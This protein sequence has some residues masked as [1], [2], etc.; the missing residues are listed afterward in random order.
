MSTLDLDHAIHLSDLKLPVGVTIPLL[1]HGKENDLPLVSIHIPRAK[2]E[3]ETKVETT[4]EVKTET[5]PS[6][7]AK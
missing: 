6:P 2:V 3:E 4:T 5:K 1:A 7:E